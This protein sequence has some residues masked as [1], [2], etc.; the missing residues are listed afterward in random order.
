MQKHFYFMVLVLNY[1]VLQEI[2]CMETLKE[3]S[4]FYFLPNSDLVK[5]VEAKY[6][7]RNTFLFL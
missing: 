1:N 3:K 4:M 6:I 2:G 5:I 7:H